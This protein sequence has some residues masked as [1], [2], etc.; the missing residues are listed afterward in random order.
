MW[1][2]L[3]QAVYHH[4]PVDIVQRLLEYGALKTLRTR[5]SEFEHPNMSPLELAYDMEVTHLY[6]ILSP[7]IKRPLPPETMQRLQYNFHRLIRSEV[8]VR[9]DSERLY[10]PV[11]EALT[12]LD[13]GETV[14]FPV[15]FGN[16][17]AVSTLL[18]VCLFT[19]PL[20][21][22]GSVG[23]EKVDRST[24]HHRASSPLNLF[25]PFTFTPSDTNAKT[26][27]ACVFLGVFVST[28]RQ[29]DTGEIGKHPNP[30]RGEAIPRHGG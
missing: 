7:V 21:L 22:G 24:F 28:L 16:E 13:V 9:V 23:W 4:A 30:Q 3:H 26:D 1:T 27:C 18:T 5:T 6:P 14:W 29:G 8:G 12:E 2:P 15:K 11:V 25:Q 19:L 10:L 20:N 17:S